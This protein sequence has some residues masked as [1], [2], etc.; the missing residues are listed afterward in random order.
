MF[1]VRT[2]EVVK[3]KYIERCIRKI[4]GLRAYA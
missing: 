2:V 3:G 4:T 1:I